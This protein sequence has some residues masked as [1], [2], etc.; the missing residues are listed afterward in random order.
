M[1][2]YCRSTLFDSDDCNSESIDISETT[3]DKDY[4]VVPSD[5]SDHLQANLEHEYECSEHNH[6]EASDQKTVIVTCDYSADSFVSSA[7]QLQYV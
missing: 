3:D 7:S 4:I 2:A 1:F 5:Q 6:V